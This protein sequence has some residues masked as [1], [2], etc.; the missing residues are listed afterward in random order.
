MFQ[1]LE[2][3]KTI[4]NYTLA[5]LPSEITNGLYILTNYELNLNIQKSE[6]N[7]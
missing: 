2:N 1:F 5:Y 7:P 4:K 3:E 6:V